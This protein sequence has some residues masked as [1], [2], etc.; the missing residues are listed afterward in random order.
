M[1]IIE[2]LVSGVS[3]GGEMARKVGFTASHI[4]HFDLV[5][6]GVFI[7]EPLADAIAGDIIGVKGGFAG[8][9]DGV[10]FVPFMRGLLEFLV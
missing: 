7:L 8:F 4:N 5:I 9:G 1:V 2:E 6:K 3:L 10:V